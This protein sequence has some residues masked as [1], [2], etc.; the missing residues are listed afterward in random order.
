MS[1][2]EEHDAEQAEITAMCEAGTCDHPE[3]HEEDFDICRTCSR[4]LDDNGECASCADASYEDECVDR[5]A[6]RW[7]WEIIDAT[8]A[9]DATSKAFDSNLRKQ[10]SDALAAMIQACETGAD[11]LR[12]G[13]ASQDEEAGQ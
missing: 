11:R 8:L 6:P 1:S 10:I 2:L 4:R 9:A 7:A 5:S 12:R 13:E 3:C